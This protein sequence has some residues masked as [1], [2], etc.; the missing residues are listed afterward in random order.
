MT[1]V[2]SKAEDDERKMEAK[3]VEA[4]GELLTEGRHKITTVTVRD[5]TPSGARID[6]NIQGEVKGKYN[7]NTMETLNIT[8]KPDG[9]SEGESKGIQL[10]PDGDTIFI[11]TKGRGRNSGSNT[12][13]A[14][15]EVNFQ[16]P[17][18]KLAWLN[19]TKARFEATANLITG[20]IREK[21]YAKK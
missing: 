9:T 8:I 6:Y 19:S 12:V 10:T 17:S 13:T 3:Y 18:A 11:T 1:K 20:E 4:K 15:G 16:T 5:F 2:P 14:E 7:A 21:I